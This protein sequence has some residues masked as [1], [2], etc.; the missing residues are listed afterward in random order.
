M[1]VYEW[2]D[3]TAADFAVIGDPVSHSLSPRMHQAA[4]DALGLSFRYVAVRVPAGEV[5]LA[6]DH[7]ALMGYQGANVTVPHKAEALAWCS[8]VE[9][10]ARSVDAVNTVRL[11]SREGINTDGPGF[12][13]TLAVLG[14]MHGDVLMLGAGGSA[15]ALARALVEAHCSLRIYNRTH[16]RAVEL[17]ESVGEKAVEFPDPMGASLILNTTSSGLGGETLSVDWSRASVSAVAYDLM[18]ME[19][20]TPFLK[21]AADAGMKV[22]DGRELLVAQGARSFEWWTGQSAPRRAMREALG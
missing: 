18:Y 16:S 11:A 20:L 4:Y 22:V 19:G 13:D 7:L 12:L 2:R 10:F 14:P 1:N 3:A 6:L 8:T 9:P 17:A 15:R 21:G 5:H